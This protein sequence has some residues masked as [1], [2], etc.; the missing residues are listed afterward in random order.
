[1]ERQVVIASGEMYP[2]WGTLESQRRTR[3]VAD[4]RRFGNPGNG[5]AHR[6]TDRRRGADPPKN[7]RGRTG[8]YDESINDSHRNASS[9]NG[10]SIAVQKISIGEVV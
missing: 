10:T 6:T 4:K 3:W 9:G 1:M 2:E 8:T 7:E 5:T